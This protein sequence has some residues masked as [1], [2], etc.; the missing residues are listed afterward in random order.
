MKTRYIQYY[1]EGEDEEKLINV[2]KTQLKVIKTGRVQRFN[3]IDKEITDMRLRTLSYGTMVVLVFDTDTNNVDTLTKNIR[4]LK[5]HPSV[6]EVVLI[7]QVPN[8]EKELIRCCDIKRIEELLNSKSKTEFKTDIVRV[9]NLAS[10]LSEHNFDINKFWVGQP[11]SPYE[12][13]ENQS[14]R[15]KLD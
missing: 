14:A 8:L 4:I 1:V 12:N 11:T 13:I 9:T 2:L 6:S 7:P 15:I 10:K 3:V 5:A